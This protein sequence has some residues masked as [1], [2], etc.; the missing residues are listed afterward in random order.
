MSASL[1]YASPESAFFWIPERRV[2]A[3]RRNCRSGGNILFIRKMTCR[4]STTARK[5]AAVLRQ[6]FRR[7]G[8]ATSIEASR[9]T[10][11]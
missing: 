11:A 6:F 2:V 5:L 4:R 7:A 3:V 10:T 1:S 8:E 9:R